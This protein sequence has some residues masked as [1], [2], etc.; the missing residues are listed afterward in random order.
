M[1]AS[2]VTETFRKR[3]GLGLGRTRQRVAYPGRMSILKP[4]LVVAMVFTIARAKT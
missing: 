1:I 2:L 4:A 3:Y